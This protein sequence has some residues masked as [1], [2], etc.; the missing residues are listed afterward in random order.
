MNFAF[1][2]GFQI[3]IKSGMT[4]ERQTYISGSEVSSFIK[5]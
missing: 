5:D 4:I 1:D 2:T 3:R